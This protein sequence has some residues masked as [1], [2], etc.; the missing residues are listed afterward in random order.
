MRHL[1]GLLC[2]VCCA[3]LVVGLG[4]PSS[5]PSVQTAIREP[6]LPWTDKP[7]ANQ[8]GT[9]H[10]AIIA[11]LT[12]GERPGVF[13]RAVTTLNLLQPE[14]VMSIGDFVQGY[15]PTAR[16]FD[17]Q[18]KSF[19]DR[20]DKLQM[21]FFFV[22]GNHDIGG[23]SPKVA[24]KV[25]A[26]KIG[27]TYYHF[28]YRDVLFLCLDSE[29]LAEPE[30][31]GDEAARQMDYIARTLEANADARWT[32]VFLHRPLWAPIAAGQWGEVQKLLA[33]RKHTVFAG[34]IHRYTK[35]VRNG[36]S[37]ITLATTGGGSGP[38]GVLKTG[39]FDEVAWVTVTPQGPVIANVLVD[40][41]LD[42][43][44]LTEEKVLEQLKGGLP[45]D[46]VP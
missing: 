40:G 46:M 38:A 19:R 21:R 1:A 7:L 39:R 11:D 32:F 24:R 5:A 29:M 31:F 23:P 26:E 28:V 30:P 44:V 43:N 2:A 34:H 14:L 42:E 27:P 20:L 33:G 41:V 35:C 4:E 13:E 10:F 12:A 36:Q 6:P 3:V 15:A 37:Y 25:Y 8:P 16:Q 22:P 9:F 18:W 45:K 17:P